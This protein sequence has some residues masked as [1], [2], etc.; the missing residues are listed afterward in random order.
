MRLIRGA[1]GAGKTAQVFREFKQAL[2]DNPA[3]AQIVVPTATL[4]RHFQHELARDGVVFSPSAVVSLNRFVRDRAPE[5]HQ[6][7]PGL[8]RAIVRSVLLE[9][10]IPEFAEVAGTDG[11]TS[12]IIDTISLFENAGCT[13]ERLAAV[14]KLSSH[15][16]AFEKV[17]RAVAAKVRDCGYDSRVDLFRSAAT[18]TGGMRLWFDGFLHFSSLETELI[19]SLAKTCDL[20]L[21]LSDSQAASEIRRLALEMGAQDRLLAA[22]PRK[23]GITTVATDSIEREADEIA[24]RIVA[25]QDR[26]IPFREIGVALRDSP[27][28]LALLRA[29]F[30]RF[31]IP[32]RYYFASALVWHPAATFLSG[33][34]ECVLHGWEFG[35]TLD[36]LRA[37]PGW[38]KSAVFDRFDFQVR[39]AMP[40]RGADA[41]LALAEED[42][43][44]RM[45]HCF[46]IE[47]WG[48]EELRATDWIRRFTLLGESLY[49]PGM[50]DL[51]R[52]FAAVETMRSHVAGL[53]AW[54]DAI[55]SVSSFWPESESLTL[56][57]FWRVASE[58]IDATSVQAPD[59]RRDVVHVMSVFEARQWNVTTLFVCG[60]TDRD[61][62]KKNPQNLLFSDPDID[63][64]RKSGIPLRKAADSDREEDA[65]F[66]SLKGRA[67]ESLVLTWPAHDAAGK[68]VESSRYIVNLRM[69]NPA[70]KFE[71]ARL[72]RPA[73]VGEP[74]G[75]S[76]AGRI[77]APA[78]LASLAQQHQRI[79]LTALEDMV[80]CRFRFFAGR[81]LGLKGRPE[82]PQ[83]RL[84]PRVTGLILHEALEAWLQLRRTGDFVALFEAAFD[85]ACR[86]KHLPPGYRLEVE[87]MQLRNIASR[88]SASE[89]W[90]PVDSQPEVELALDFPGGITVNCRVDRIDLMNDRDCVILDYKSSRTA[91]VEQFVE[92]QVKL[93]GPLYALAAREQRNLNT[94]AMMYVAVREDKRFGWGA[95]PGVDLDL[96]EMP[97]NWIED[98]RARAVGRIESFLG[99][100][101]H[102]EPVEPDQCRWCDYAQACR[103]ETKQGLV[104]ITGAHGA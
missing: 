87:R 58:S 19:R 38:G 89:Q 55:A 6:T 15:G 97:P 82:R 65:L 81:T 7:P 90:T 1:P 75:F 31:G 64:L 41:L 52:D 42:L 48:K 43:A 37:H 26:G 53:R 59:D 69:E 30:E 60:M 96:K 98:A 34:I 83:E 33:L 12:T 84:Q 46:A 2:R 72:C 73:P 14:R 35:R 27:S 20:T 78:L 4:V 79:S 101:I 50:I 44:K 99:G 21:T 10:T 28:Y 74:A 93:Q 22:S 29:T 85:K 3:T 86:E 94:I 36:T 5:R 47:A 103:Y 24:R 17:W 39:E 100:A 32:A 18:N 45:R 68:S 56:E 71:E 104:M 95:V 25:S 67:D 92:S 40:G 51:P 62:P 77:D 61:Y 16:K 76:L 11:M 54:C 57:T 8:L 80:Q 9:A 63:A 102:P 70:P 66:E 49:R 91:R 88:V 23:S 13:P